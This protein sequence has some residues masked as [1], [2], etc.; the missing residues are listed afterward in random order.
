MTRF[1]ELCQAI[2]AVG[3]IFL[4]AAVISPGYGFESEKE[5]KGAVFSLPLRGQNGL[6][7]Q[8]DFGAACKASRLRG[9]PFARR[10]I[11]MDEIRSQQ[12]KAGYL[13]SWINAYPWNRQWCWL[14]ICAFMMWLDYVTG[15]HISIPI[16]FIAPVMMAA[17]HSTV[18]VAV[19]YAVGLT[20]VRLLF[21]FYSWG[22][23][24]GAEVAVE[25]ALM[26]C[27]VLV[28]VAMLTNRVSWQTRELKKQ[29]RIMEGAFPICSFCKSIQDS[30]GKWVHLDE[31][32]AETSEER[33]THHFCPEC[34]EKYYNE[35][36]KT[37]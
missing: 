9:S 30:K 32:I 33:F 21:Q 2:K 15:P 1:L 4:R 27:A 14:L 37:P 17:W 20:V 25:N 24:L 22:F 16:L 10:D 28:V 11:P 26:R 19:A 35:A 5:A 6:N 34:M 3:A 8:I 7:V 18:R 31:Y 29:M 23:A 36:K 12:S 13:L